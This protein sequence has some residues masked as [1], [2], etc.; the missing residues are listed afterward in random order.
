MTTVSSGWTTTQTLSSL[1]SD[2]PVFCANAE[3][4]CMPIARP[5][6]AAADVT[7]NC[8]RDCLNCAMAI[9]LYAFL[10]LPEFDFAAAWIA[11]RMRAYVPQRQMF[12][13]AASMSASL[14]FGF[15]LRSATAAMIWPDWQ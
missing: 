9:P 1:P 11:V 4:M 15:A 2:A 5:P 13:I 8:R 6:D 7:R 12:V 14:G 10:E 3:G